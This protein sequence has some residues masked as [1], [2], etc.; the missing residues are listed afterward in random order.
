MCGDTTAE[1]AQFISCSQMA[2]HHTTL[3]LLQFRR[4]VTRP[5]IDA[6][7]AALTESPAARQVSAQGSWQ[8]PR[9]RM[10]SMGRAPPHQAVP[11]APSAV[12]VHWQ[13]RELRTR[14]HPQKVLPQVECVV[15][16]SAS[17][18]AVSEMP[19]PSHSGILQQLCMPHDARSA[20]CRE[21]ATVIAQAQHCT[22]STMKVGYRF[23]SS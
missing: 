7:H 19:T 15:P 5:R 1:Q 21:L 14:V 11:D 23:L 8:R 4:H 3:P 12:H 17:R 6:Q 9:P 18:T 2:P 13:Q 16:A 22:G 20:C 10:P